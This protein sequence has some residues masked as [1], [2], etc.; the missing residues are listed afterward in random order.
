MEVQKIERIVGKRERNGE[1]EYEM[2]FKGYVHYFL[3]FL[4]TISS[5]FPYQL[6]NRFNYCYNTWKKASIL[7]DK[8]PQLI[9]SFETHP[10]KDTLHNSCACERCGWPSDTVEV[11]DLVWAMVKRVGKERRAFRS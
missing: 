8:V 5:S 10:G 4:R 2:K 6:L 11:G 3:L 7:K 1:A 9:D